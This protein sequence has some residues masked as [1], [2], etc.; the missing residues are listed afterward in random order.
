MNLDSAIFYT[1]DLDR[2]IAFHRDELGFTLKEVQG[3]KFASFQFDNGAKLGIKVADKPREIP[4]SQTVILTVSG[5]QNLYNG[6]QS[7]SLSIFSELSVQSWGTTF[8]ILDI[9]GNRIE[10]VEGGNE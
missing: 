9:D 6:Y 3:T 4:G 5:I 10:F 7:K 2:A 1:K 8:S